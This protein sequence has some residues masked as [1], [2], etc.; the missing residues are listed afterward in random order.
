MQTVVARSVE[1]LENAWA[2]R[3]PARVVYAET[4]HREEWVYNISD[5]LN[6][7]RSLVSMQFLD[8]T[9]NSIATLN[10]FACHPTIMDGRSTEISADYVGGTYRILDQELGGENL[11]LQGAIGGWVQ[12]EYVPQTFASAQ[13]KGTGLGQAILQALTQATPLAHTALKYRSRVF[14][15]PV[16]NVNFQQLAGIGVIQRDFT[17]SVETEIAWFSVGPAQFI[18]HPGETTPTHS[19]RSKALMKTTGPKFVLGLGMDALG[20]I[21]TPDFYADPPPVK[22]A[23]YQGSMS[24]DPAAGPLLMQEIEKIIGEDG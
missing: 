13:E 20:Y 16:S 7:D 2:R 17:D 10:N 3:Q 14:S 4:Q 9:G 18:T 11:F 21:L 22:H 12:P 6:L 19:Q 8:Q 15:L 24:I 23:A 5:S 1:A